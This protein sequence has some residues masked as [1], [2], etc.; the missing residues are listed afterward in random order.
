MKTQIAAIEFGTS[1]I[2]TVVAQNGGISRNEI[3][4]SGTVPY[5]G[6][7][8]GDWNQP[9]MLIDAVKDSIAAA[10]IEASAKIREAYIGVP[11]A[12]VHVRTAE[13]EVDSS[14]D[15]VIT[16]DTINLVQDEVARKLKIGEDE[17]YVLH[18]SPA[19][20]SVDNG[21]KT[22]MPMGARG[23]RLRA[24]ISYIIA[25]PQFIDD[26]KDLMGAVGVTIMG[27]LS[28]TLGQALT[29]L[30]IEDRDRVAMLIDVGYISTEISVMEGDGIIYHATFED[31]GGFMVG[32]M[33]SALKVDVDVAEQIKRAF[34]F[35]PDEFDQDN[36]YEARDEEGR[37]LQ[38]TRDVVTRVVDEQMDQ[39][40]DKIDKTLKNDAAQLFGPR[41]QVYL[42]GGGIALMRGGR[43]YLAAR[44]G[45]TVKVPAPKAARLNS[46]I[47][48][49]ALG[50]I[51]L[52]FDSLEQTE[53]EGGSLKEKFASFLKKG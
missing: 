35:N 6:Y 14:D 15:G 18:R 40:C 13:A 26:M 38:F 16:E 53:T 23:R 20:F 3:I 41:T 36:F 5:A 28:P 31:G 21:K 52:I 44:L 51:N 43:E 4:G 39:L 37:M 27:F 48:T 32:E 49:S 24:C 42:T 17:G 46:P 47:Y 33:A 7:S 12:F 34:L 11:G 8:E 29:L 22:M 19:W 2:V 50:L 30:S 25:D 9:D 1:K 45:R 10:E